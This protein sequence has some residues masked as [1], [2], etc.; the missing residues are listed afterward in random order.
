MNI[1][2]FEKNKTYDEAEV[3]EII[4]SAHP[5]FSDTAVKWELF[6]LLKEGVITRV[7]KKRYVA[8]GRRYCAELSERALAVDSFLAKRY[9]EVDYVLWESRQLNE[10]I[11]FLLA[12][13]VVFVEAEKSLKD[14]VFAALLE[15]FGPNHA[16]LLDPD[17]VALSRYIDQEPIVV[18]SLF[19]RSP[20]SRN[21]HLIA[22]EKLLIDVLTDRLLRGL[23]SPE[24]RLE[25]S[26]RMA[27]DYSLNQTTAIAYAQRRG[28]EAELRRILE[29]EHD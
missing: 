5:S 27:M 23:I 9:P 7:G 17:A 4:R 8:G 25:A 6:E 10:W 24:D 21:G 16:V 28:C 13:N 3:I 22:I 29:G 2:N 18:R 11:H 26:T 20:R 19:S 15:E 12:K 14:Y 1:A